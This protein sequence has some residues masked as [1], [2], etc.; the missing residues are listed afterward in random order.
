MQ[1]T[2]VGAEVAVHLYAVAVKFQLRRIQQSFGAGKAGHYV[3][4]R[5]DKIDDIEHRPVRHGGGD[6]ARHRVRYGGLYV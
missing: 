3:V 4:H 6:V 2:D 5:L 1:A